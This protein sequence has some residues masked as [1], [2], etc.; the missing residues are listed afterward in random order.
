[1]ITALCRLIHRAF[2]MFLYGRSCFRVR[3]VRAA[4]QPVAHLPA[5]E[6]REAV[7]GVDADRGVAAVGVRVGIRRVP[8]LVRGEQGGPFT[9][10]I[11]LVGVKVAFG[12]HHRGQNVVAGGGQVVGGAGQ[13][14]KDLDQL[15]VWVDQ[16]PGADAVGV[17]V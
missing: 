5:F 2:S 4:A 17:H 1:M 10:D 7:F 6:D 14:V 8:P 3:T 13:P 12:G 15:A 11:A 9:T 16:P